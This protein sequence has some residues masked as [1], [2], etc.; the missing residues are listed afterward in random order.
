[1]DLPKRIYDVLSKYAKEIFMDRLIM[2]STNAPKEV[3]KIARMIGRV[4]VPLRLRNRRIL[5][6]TALAA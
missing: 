5:R 6:E 1:M 3:L 2:N 4:A